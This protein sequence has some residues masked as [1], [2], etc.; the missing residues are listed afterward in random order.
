LKILKKFVSIWVFIRHDCRS[1]NW[2]FPLTLDVYVEEKLVE[3]CCNGKK[4]AYTTLVKTYSQYVFAICLGIV[5]N[6]Y[7][8][9]DLAQQA[10]L[11]GFTDIKNLQNGGRFKSWIGQIARNLCIDFL[12]KQKC[13][14]KGLAERV[15]ENHSG[16]K[17]CPELQIAIV[18]LQEEYRLAC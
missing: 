1:Q 5:G 17:E 12:R 2:E 14:Q 3:S 13:D 18:K 6:I 9:E 16:S 10:L 11:K 8:A 15:Y 4:S 7:D